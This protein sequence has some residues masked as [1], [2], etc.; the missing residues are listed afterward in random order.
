MLVRL[1]HTC[2]A[3]FVHPWELTRSAGMYFPYLTQSVHQDVHSAKMDPYKSV[4][5]NC[6]IVKISFQKTLKSWC[7]SRVMWRH[8]VIQ[9][10]HMTSRRHAMTS[11]DVMTSHHRPRLDI[12]SLKSENL[13]RDVFLTS[14]PWPMTLTS[15]LVRDIVNVNVCT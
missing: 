10:H 12:C 7:T 13:E 3:D 8:D 6:L 9:W 1:S 5:G 2:L 11:C 15:K 4:C 14:W